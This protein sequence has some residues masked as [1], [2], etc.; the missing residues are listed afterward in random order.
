VLDAYT[1]GCRRSVGLKMRCPP[2]V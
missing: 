1:I 2:F